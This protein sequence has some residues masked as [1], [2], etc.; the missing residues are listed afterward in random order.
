MQSKKLL[1]IVTGMI[2]IVSFVLVLILPQ[3][4]KTYDLILAL[5]GSAALGCFMS[6]AEYYVAR[7]EAMEDFYNEVIKLWQQLWDLPTVDINIP[8]NLFKKVLLEN[9]NNESAR[10]LG[11][12]EKTEA[13]E[14][15]RDWYNVSKDGKFD[16]ESL[17]NLIN[18]NIKIARNAIES[19]DIHISTENIQ[20]V[21]GRLC[22]FSKKFQNWVFTTIYKPL[23]DR[24]DE[25]NKK[26]R[27]LHDLYMGDNRNEPVAFKEVMEISDSIYTRK[28]NDLKLDFRVLIDDKIYPL[29]NEPMIKLWENIYFPSKQELENEKKRNKKKQDHFSTLMIRKR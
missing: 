23:T 2:G 9:W 11:L 1:T 6:L 15:L 16:D 28:E 10:L 20:R 8:M 27:N 5:F 21:Y 18:K 13:R 7:R 3:A 17:D 12:P 24:V 14:K 29:L 26:T 4:S 19:Y 25:I 22:F